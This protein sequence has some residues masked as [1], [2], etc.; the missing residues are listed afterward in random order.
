MIALYL[1]FR[2]PES[3]APYDFSIFQKAL[4]RLGARDVPQGNDLA[5][6]FKVLR[7]LMTFLEK[8]G[9]VVSAMQRHLHPRRHFQ[10]KTMLLVEDFCRFTAGQATP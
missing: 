2:Y 7:T 1:A 3:Y 9:A 8:D 10:G 6:Y 4:A 5:R